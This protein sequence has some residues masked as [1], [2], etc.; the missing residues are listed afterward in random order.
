MQTTSVSH[1]Q[2][3]QNGFA[4]KKLTELDLTCEFDGQCRITPECAEWAMRTINLS[5]RRLRN[6][7][8]EFLC[9]QIKSGEW[10]ED[11]P[12]PI[13][14]SVIP[15]MIDGQHRM[16]GIFLSG[17]TVTAHIRTGVRDSLREY[18]DTGISRKLEDRVQFVDDLS[19]N[20]R[21]ASIV[22][23]MHSLKMVRSGGSGCSWRCSP[24]EAMDSFNLHR[25]GILFAAEVM[26]HRAKGICRTAVMSAFVFFYERDPDRAQ[27]FALSLL[28]PDGPV[29]PARILRDWLL[30]NTVGSS[31]GMAQRDAF[32]RCVTAMKA[33]IDGREIKA[34]RCSDW[35]WI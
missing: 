18:L 33:A 16:Q 25:Q 8:A 14:F 21:C 12:Q 7:F 15:R 22:T 10:Q 29:Q 17:C 9:R 2:I 34:L 31:G 6:H 26:G 1:N 13:V 20:Q 3:S 35:D 11:H 28:Q 5:N 32:L 4:I 27:E 30:R 24:S 19:L 23:A